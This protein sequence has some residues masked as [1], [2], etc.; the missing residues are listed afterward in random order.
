[1]KKILL[2][3]FFASFSLIETHAIS[4]RALGCQFHNSKKCRDAKHFE[5]E[6][7]RGCASSAGNC[8]YEFCKSNCTVSD[9]N[10]T[11][12]CQQHCFHQAILMRFD[13][14][15][16]RKLYHVNYPKNDVMTKENPTFNPMPNTKNREYVLKKEQAVHAAK[17]KQWWRFGRKPKNTQLLKDLEKQYQEIQEIINQKIEELKK[18]QNNG[19]KRAEQKAYA[20]AVA[21]AVS[22]A[23]EIVLIEVEKANI[24]NQIKNDARS[25]NFQLAEEMPERKKAQN[26]QEIATALLTSAGASPSIIQEASRRASIS[27]QGSRRYSAEKPSVP[28]KSEAYQ[29]ASSRLSSRRASLA[30]LEGASAAPAIPPAP[31]MEGYNPYVAGKSQKPS[32]VPTPQKIKNSLSSVAVILPHE[33]GSTSRGALLAQIQE[34]RQLKKVKRN[35]SSASVA[36]DSRNNLLE[37]IKKPKKLKSSK[38]REVNYMPSAEEIAAEKRITADM[39]KDLQA[40][41]KELRAKKDSANSEKKRYERANQSYLAKLQSLER[42]QSTAQADI[43]QAN[44]F[45]EDATTSNAAKS[46]KKMELRNTLNPRLVAAQQALKDH[47]LTSPQRPKTVFSD[48]DEALMKTLEEELKPLQASL[49]KGAAE[50]VLET[51]TFKKAEQKQAEA[52]Q[53]AASDDRGPGDSASEDEWGD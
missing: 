6:E 19:D 7:K 22:A 23:E 12:L 16:R 53:Q 34:G 20:E 41:I 48:E 33:S 27:S 11:D 51:S 4:T 18:A 14:K 37:E 35:S 13:E 3:L 47:K 24:Q 52:A 2:S 25:A 44:A 36:G 21:L 46:Q 17:K 30:S 10:L 40:K 50:A 49:K 8:R 26:T 39:A 15:T 28:E 43:N 1:M 38:T 5:K 29:R 9:P 32:T 45:I 42:A 31:S